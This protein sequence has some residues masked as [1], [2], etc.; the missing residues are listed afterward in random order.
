MQVLKEKKGEVEHLQAQLASG[1]RTLTDTERKGE[2]VS[3]ELREAK[4]RGDQLGKELGLVR[5]DITVLAA[6]FEH[7][8]AAPAGLLQ[9]ETPVKQVRLPCP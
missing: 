6:I 8:K 7:L 1:R 3:K 4:A 2:L 5:Q 9:G